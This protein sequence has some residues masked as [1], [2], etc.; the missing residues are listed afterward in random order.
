MTTIIR[1]HRRVVDNSGMVF[2]D[3][4]SE[5]KISPV[6]DGPAPV[7]FDVIDKKSSRMI[8]HTTTLF[9]AEDLV[10]TSKIKVEK[11]VAGSAA[12]VECG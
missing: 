5:L 6:Y 7:G 9:S 10:R 1:N 3:E 11:T 2:Y 12:D 8:G 4:S